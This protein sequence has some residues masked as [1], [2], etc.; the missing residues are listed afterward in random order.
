M[1]N[2]RLRRRAFETEM[3]NWELRGLDA[4]LKEVSSPG[5]GETSVGEI[6]ERAAAAGLTADYDPGE[7]A[8]LPSRISRPLLASVGESL[9]AISETISSGGVQGPALDLKAMTEADLVGKVKT[10]TGIFFLK[11]TGKVF[12]NLGEA[13]TA[14]DIYGRALSL[15]KD[16]GEQEEEGE[17]LCT[18]G[19][20][21]L[22][23]GS[24]DCLT[25]LEQAIS[26]QLKTGSRTGL[27]FCYDSMA[28]YHRNREEPGKAHRFSMKALELLEGEGNSVQRASC[29]CNLALSETDQ[30]RYAVAKDHLEQAVALL[31]LSDRGSFRNRVVSLLSHAWLNLGD[32]GNARALLKPLENSIRGSSEE[33]ELEYHRAMYRCSKVSGEP[34]K[35]LESFERFVEL[36]RRVTGQKRRRL[37]DITEEEKQKQRGKRERELLSETNLQLVKTNLML[38]EAENAADAISEV[39]P[40]CSGCRG[41]RDD[42]EYWKSLDRFIEQN[43]RAAS[44]AGICPKCSAAAGK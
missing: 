4:Y 29:L 33:A 35:A 27:A 19:G 32:T 5:G 31:D 44:A 40:V 41:M 16:S 30:K 23:N 7:S 43:G 24:S 6:L 37:M 18:M 38:K 13:R 15:A 21:F 10:R 8:G 36:N 22:Q 14:L 28:V 39:L 2:H 42:E 3:N 34:E 12:M 20:L 17:I 1:S 25:Y 11:L 26:V 9:R